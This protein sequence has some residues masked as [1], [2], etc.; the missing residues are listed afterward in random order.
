[1]TARRPGP[2]RVLLACDFMLRYTAALAGGLHRAGAEVTLLTRDHDLEFGGQPGAAHAF[3][4]RMAGGVEH[5]QLT[6]RVRSPAG[7]A[8]TV[9]LRRRLRPFAPD[10]VHVQQSIVSD[11]RLLVA[12]GVRRGRFAVTYHDPSIHPG[13]DDVRWI[14]DLAN[15]M[16][17]GSAGLIFVHGE[18]LAEELGE[19]V[20]PRAPVVVVPH[21]VDPAPVEPLPDH[22]ALLFFGRISY[23]KG[24]DTLLDAMGAVWD[25]CPDAT[26][27]IAGDGALDDH[28]AL[29]DPRVT[30]RAEHVPD[31][32]V[33]GL[34]GESTCVVLP[35]RQ[36]SQSGVGSL[37]KPYGR[38]LVATSVGGLPELLSDGSGLLVPPEDP[39]A[40]ATALVSVLTDRE[41][42]LGLAAAGV[43]TASSDGSWEAVGEQ[44]LDAYT[45][46]LDSP[47]MRRAT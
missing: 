32:E 6:G 21:G 45:R 31:S 24:I 34:I 3:I 33:P 8:E 1:M 18:A 29:A 46:Y 9:R 39:A 47:A 25:R 11:V 27:T 40:L 20:A 16:L 38:P 41:L 14:D 37:V 43:R 13:D 28:P 42:A 26:L 7:L 17:A 5:V 15:R 36:A 10:V 19:T 4:E 22:P 30:V 12:A 35:Y 2:P 44:T 23:Y